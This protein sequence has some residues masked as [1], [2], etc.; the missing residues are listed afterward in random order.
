MIF[1]GLLAAMGTGLIIFETLL[2]E[3]CVAER[4]NDEKWKLPA[5]NN[6]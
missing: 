4:F 1:V 2:D 3:R 6:C 5:D